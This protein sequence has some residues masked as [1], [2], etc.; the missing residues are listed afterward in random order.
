MTSAVP[1][2]WPGDDQ[3]GHQEHAG[4]HRHQQLVPVV[5]AALLVGVDVRH[6]QDHRELGDLGRL[7]LHRTEGQPVGVAVDLDAERGPGQHQQEDRHHQPDPGEAAQH[8]LRHPRGDERRGEAE[9]HPHQLALDHGVGVAA[10]VL[11]GVDARGRQH[12][13]HADGEQQGRG[14]EQ[15]VVAGQRPVER[16]AQG[17]EPAGRPTPQRGVGR[18]ALRRRAGHHVSC[19]SRCSVLS[20][21]GPPRRTGLRV[22]RSWR[23]CPSRR[24]R[25]PAAPCH[26]DGPGRLPP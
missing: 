15:Q 20:C 18:L 19:V 1:R 13:D 8:P 9:P 12:H 24:I 26:R 5:Q 16:L 22:R 23:T 14:A 17:G 2:S 7:D 10:V 4:D 25:G 11:V 6:P 3:A 21:G